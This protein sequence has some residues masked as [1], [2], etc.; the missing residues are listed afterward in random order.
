MDSDGVIFTNSLFQKSLNL[1]EYIG[2]FADLINGILVQ[3]G[4][5]Q[6]APDYFKTFLGIN[7][8]PNRFY[9][10]EYMLKA[11]KRL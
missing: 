2:F 7:G 8:F 4:P 10:A 5:E 3:D 11:S 1:V 6:P 9:A